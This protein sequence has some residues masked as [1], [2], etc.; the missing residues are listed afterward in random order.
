MKIYSISNQFGQAAFKGIVTHFAQQVE[1]VTEALPKKMTEIDTVIVNETMSN[2]DKV[3]QLQVRPHYLIAALE[4][5]INNNHLYNNVKKLN[6]QTKQYD[7]SNII[8]TG[9]KQFQ[10]NIND[11]LPELQQTSDILQSDIN[12]NNNTSIHTNESPSTNNDQ[13]YIISNKVSILRSDYNQGMLLFSEENRG[14]QCSAMAAYSIAYSFVIFISEW[15]INDINDVILSGDSYYTECQQRLAANLHPFNRYL[16]V[17]EV[18]GSIF[19]GT[20]CINIKYR[21]NDTFNA[22]RQGVI[23]KN[24]IENHMNEFLASDTKHMILICQTYTSAIFKNNNNL[25]IFDSHAK[26]PTGRQTDSENGRA[27]VIKFKH[28]YAV[29]EITKYLIRTFDKNALYALTY[30]TAGEERQSN[31]IINNSAHNYSLI[32]NT[33]TPE[34]GRRLS[35]NLLTLK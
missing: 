17:Q 35:N 18:L 24:G 32:K 9:L 5:L 34:R 25:Y 3:N 26:T 15:S 13:Y 27:S 16:E 8:V 1:E 4:W 7:I 21:D 6:T 28:P 10:N 33:S 23:S 22:T 14:Q 20:K 12:N 29:I 31:I 19:I 2:L 30:I 11:Q